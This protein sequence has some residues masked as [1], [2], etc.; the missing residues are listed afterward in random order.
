MSRHHHSQEWTLARSR[1]LNRDGYR[2]RECGRAGRL[3]VHHLRSLK[4][5]GNHALENLRSYCKTHHLEIHRQPQT[6]SE[7]EWNQL[8]EELMK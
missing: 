5:G 6:A 8:I 4:D 1:A 7:R 3:E 2:C